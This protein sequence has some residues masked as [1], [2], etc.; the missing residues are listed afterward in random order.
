[1]SA[2]CHSPQIIRL[3]EIPG[4][5]SVRSGLLGTGGSL[6]ICWRRDRLG[7]WRPVGQLAEV[8]RYHSL[9]AQN[10]A[11]AQKQD[12]AERDADHDDLQRGC[13]RLLLG[14]EQHRIGAG[15]TRP[16]APHQHRAEDRAAIV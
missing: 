14:W 15:R 4:T 2:T 8:A 13:A 3:I 16:Y 9:L 11:R 7:R 1:M 10:P 6:A 12:G 5:M